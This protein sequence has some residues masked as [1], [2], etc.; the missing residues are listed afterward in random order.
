MP[1]EPFPQTLKYYGTFL[2]SSEVASHTSMRSVQ[3][4]PRILPAMAGMSD[5][6]VKASDMWCSNRLTEAGDINVHTHNPMKH[7]ASPNTHALTISADTH[8]H[9]AA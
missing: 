2:P 1:S 5:N 3:K 4:S 7:T 6:T 9:A 8:T